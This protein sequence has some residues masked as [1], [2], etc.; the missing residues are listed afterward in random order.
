MIK[1]NNQLP[2]R[3]EVWLDTNGTYWLISSHSIRYDHFIKDKTKE[4]TS[5]LRMDC[6]KYVEG[7]KQV[8]QGDYFE[9]Y[10]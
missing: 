4:Y 5:D 8:K 1:N 7:V 10:I 3:F 6:I 9:I 2:V